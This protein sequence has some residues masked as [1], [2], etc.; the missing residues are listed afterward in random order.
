MEACSLGASAQS[1]G[2]SRGTLEST[3]VVQR[4]GCGPSVI[5]NEGRDGKTVSGLAGVCIRRRYLTGIVLCGAI[6]YSFICSVFIF[7]NFLLSRLKRIKYTIAVTL[8]H[9]HM[10]QETRPLHLA[11]TCAVG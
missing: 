5:L 10:G 11:L 8:F 3:E 2:W 1:L 9:L 7:C 4:L 6:L